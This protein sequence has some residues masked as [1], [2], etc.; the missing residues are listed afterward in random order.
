MTE[1]MRLLADNPTI[2]DLMSQ[3]DVDLS[4]VSE[5]QLHLLVEEHATLV[6]P[7]RSGEKVSLC[8]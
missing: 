2:S 6:L 5:S 4:I 3:N 1:R 7:T 8:I